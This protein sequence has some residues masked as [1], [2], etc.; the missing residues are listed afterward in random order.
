[1]LRNAWPL[2]RTVSLSAVLFACGGDDEPADVKTGLPATEKLSAVKASDAVMVCDAVKRGVEQAVSKADID[3][4]R[5]TAAALGASITVTGGAGDNVTA[6]VDVNK[7][8]D[9]F[10]KCQRG[11]SIGEDEALDLSS[12]FE[13][14]VECKASEVEATLSK[15]DATVGDFEACLNSTIDTFRTLVNSFNCAAFKDFAAAQQK[16]AAM[17]SPSDGEACKPLQEKCADLIDELRDSES[18]SGTGN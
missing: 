4:L 1:M 2:L 15:C 18:A 12:D 14:E 10:A 13:N 11:E 6:S 8:E 7:C 5:C 16:F 17:T 3:R 9:L